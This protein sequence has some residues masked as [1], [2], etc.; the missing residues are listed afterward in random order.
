MEEKPF[1]IPDETESETAPQQTRASRRQ[2]ERAKT[3]ATQ[4][5]R[6]NRRRPAWLTALIG[7]IALA[8]FAGSAAVLAQTVQSVLH[9]SD[10]QLL[11]SL[12]VTGATASASATT[13]TAVKVTLKVS[14]KGS[15][16]VQ[17]VLNYGGKVKSTGP[18]VHS[19]PWQKS[20]T[21]K[22]ADIEG[23]TFTVTGHNRYNTNKIVATIS[24]DGK[25]VAKASRSGRFASATA[26]KT[27]SESLLKN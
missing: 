22:R 20:Y 24:V 3:A 27:L 11:R 5:S 25:V 14:G 8:V 18:T 17:T 23:A 9:P 1:W 7:V 2:A 10:D 21:V 26:N 13:K 4:T 16:R 12:G 6:R 15:T 19:L